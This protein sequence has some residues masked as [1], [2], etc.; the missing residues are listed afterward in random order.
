LHQQV[1]NADYNPNGLSYIYITDYTVHPDLPV[2][3]A[4]SAW[5]RGLEKRIVKVVLWDEQM[6]MANSVE[7]GCYYTIRKLRLMQSTM[8]GQFQGRLG[9]T[10]RLI[11]RLKSIDT[12]NARLAK[13]LQ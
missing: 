6:S 5:S 10:E 8:G 13:L 11:H 3:P 9:G 1:L 4:S 12:G 7:P 2:V